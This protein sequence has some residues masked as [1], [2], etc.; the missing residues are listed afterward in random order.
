MWFCLPPPTLPSVHLPHYYSSTSLSLSLSSLFSLL[1]SSLFQ[2]PQPFFL[3]FLLSTGL[4][5]SHLLDVPT[6]LETAAVLVSFLFYSIVLRPGNGLSA[7]PRP[8]EPNPSLT[9]SGQSGHPIHPLDL[10]ESPPPFPGAPYL[11]LSNKNLV[12]PSGYHVRRQGPSYRSRSG[13]QVR[14]H[15][16]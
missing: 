6:S 15:R 16:R 14:S 10:L 7:A 13:L 9:L 3:S 12:T 11:V 8:D 4:S 2:N 5:P 1:P